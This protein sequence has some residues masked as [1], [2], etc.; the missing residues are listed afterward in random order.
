MSNLTPQDVDA[1]CDLVDELCGIYWD[2]SKS[3]LIESRLA[4]I[5]KR[6]GC[7]N[8]VDFAQKVRA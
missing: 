1:I 2:K 4:T 5:V 6:S 3:Y 7:A 8:Y